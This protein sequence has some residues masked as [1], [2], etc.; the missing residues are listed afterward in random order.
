MDGCLPVV[1]ANSAN[2]DKSGQNSSVQVVARNS[3]AD[4]PSV[5]D[6]DKLN[7]RK[8]PGRYLK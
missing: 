4:L 6:P 8:A 7:Q 1:F 3:I 5:L 2:H